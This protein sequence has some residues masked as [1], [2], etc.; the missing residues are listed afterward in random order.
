[1]TAVIAGTAIAVYPVARLSDGHDRRL[2]LLAF[3][4]IG[5]IAESML[6]VTGYASAVLLSCL[7]LSV[8]AS[9]M[10]LYTVAI[11]HANDRA[12]PENGVE[13]SSGLL[14][15]YCI[16]AILGPSLASTLMTWFGPSALF[17]QNAVTHTILAAFIVWRLIV[18]DAFAVPAQPPRLTARA[19][20][21]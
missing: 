16:G 12:G 4:L 14:F 13:V 11:S 2:V 15:L 18:R 17:A 10:V 8:G 9:T 5:V 19:G 7:G 20:L 3:A 6:A 1:M 21:G